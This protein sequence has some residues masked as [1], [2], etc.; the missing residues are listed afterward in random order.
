MVERRMEKDHR[1]DIRAAFRMLQQGYTWDE[2][3]TRLNGP[4]PDALK[5]RFWRWI[6]DNFK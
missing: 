4:R 2:I 6:R 1:E 3:A 5:K